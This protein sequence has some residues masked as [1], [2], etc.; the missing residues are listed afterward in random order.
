MVVAGIFLILGIAFGSYK[1]AL[2][3]MLNLPLAWSAALRAYSSRE[4][5]CR[6]H[7]SWASSRCSESRR[8][9]ASC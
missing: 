9:T 2:I 3:I 8:A 5:C 6:S 7:R 1:D 4:A